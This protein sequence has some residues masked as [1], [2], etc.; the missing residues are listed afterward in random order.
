MRN[1]GGIIKSNYQSIDNR[2]GSQRRVQDVCFGLVEAAFGKREG[3]YVGR[4][5]MCSGEDGEIQT[6][7]HK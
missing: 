4:D 6:R 7:K 3:Y 5:V 1:G 2:G